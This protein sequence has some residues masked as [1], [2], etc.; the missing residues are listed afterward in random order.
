[1]TVVMNYGMGVDS[2]TILLRWLLE[3]DSRDFGLDE[4]CVVSSQTGNEFPDT[5]RMVETYMLP[6]FRLHRVRYV[7]MARKGPL[8]ADGISVLSDTRE[9][10]VLH[11]E[12]VY[13]LSDELLEAGTGPQVAS[14]RCSLKSKGVVIDTWLAQEMGDEPFRQVMGFNADEQGRIERDSCYGGDNRNAHYPL[15]EWGWG[16]E[17]CEKYLLDWVGEPWPKSCCTM[18][19][20]TRG[21]EGVLARFRA[22]PEHAAEALLVELMAMALNPRMTLYAHTSLW[23]L[24]VQDGNEAAFEALFQRTDGM[25]WA[26]YLVRRTYKRK[27]QADRSVKVIDQGDRGRMYFRLARLAEATEAHV[28]DGYTPRFFTLHREPGVY[29][30]HEEMFVAAPMLARDKE[31]KSFEATWASRIPLLMV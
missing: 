9:P 7:Q 19:P 22:M 13:K 23:D 26:V 3:P 6:L 12:G 25:P 17:A 14:R 31:K 8:R 5:C 30:T 21:K 24:L 11:T 15:M 2:T 4:L 10:H 29:P 18:C 27:G 28:E 20:F 1:M 16:R